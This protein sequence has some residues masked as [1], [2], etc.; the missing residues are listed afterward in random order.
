MAG[1]GL[2]I[3]RPGVTDAGILSSLE[4]DQLTGAKRE[5]LP[6]RRLKNSEVF[7]L[8]GLRFYLL[9]MM[10]VVAYQLWLGSR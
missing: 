5:R 1:T 10:G 3:N 9:F 8:W 2:T 4:P 7:L 6:R